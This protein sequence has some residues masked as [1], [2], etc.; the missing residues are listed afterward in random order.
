MSHVTMATPV[1]TVATPAAAMPTRAR[2]ARHASGPTDAM[3]S[4]Q[5]PDSVSRPRQLAAHRVLLAGAV[6]PAADVLPAAVQDVKAGSSDERRHAEHAA[7]TVASFTVAECPLSHSQLASHRI[8]PAGADLPA[9]AVLPAAV[10][11][12]IPGQAGGFHYAEVSADAEVCSAGGQRSGPRP[13]LATHRDQP[14]D[15]ALPAAVAAPAAVGSPALLQASRCLHAAPL[16]AAPDPTPTRLA[17]AR[18]ASDDDDDL[19]DDDYKHR[20]VPSACLPLLPAEPV[21]IRYLCAPLP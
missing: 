5:G 14:A 6:L 15:A 4:T 3:P 1:L 16:P 12:A 20:R 21:P 17:D 7:S 9:A 10:R 13:H 2:P 19:W 18:D 8:H 11:N